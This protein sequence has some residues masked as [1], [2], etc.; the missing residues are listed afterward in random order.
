MRKFYYNPELLEDITSDE[1]IVICASLGA[2]KSE[3]VKQYITGTIKDKI[4][5]PSNYERARLLLSNIC[6]G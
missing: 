2:G 1:S 6:E 5:Q 3:S 4:L